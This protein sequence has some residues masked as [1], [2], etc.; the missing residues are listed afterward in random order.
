[1]YTF[2]EMINFHTW[3]HCVYLLTAATYY[4][5]MNG[6][7]LILGFFLLSFGPL[8]TYFRTSCFDGF[9][10]FAKENLDHALTAELLLLLDF[11]FHG[12]LI[13]CQPDQES[14]LF[15][16]FSIISLLLLEGFSF[17]Q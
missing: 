8:Q 6:S 1:M 7:R 5:G 10:V 15:M 11:C 2:N 4:K 3:Q 17:F 13:V 14:S 12:F 9:H 16:S